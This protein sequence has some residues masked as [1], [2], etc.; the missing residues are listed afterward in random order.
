MQNKVL[1]ILILTAVICVIGG[2]KH[3]THIHKLEVI[4]IL[5]KHGCLDDNSVYRCGGV[6]VT[7]Y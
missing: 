1:L 5:E 6:N 4:K 7:Y 2:I 3:Q